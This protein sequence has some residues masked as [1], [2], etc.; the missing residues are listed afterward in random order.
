[1]KSLLDSFFEG[2]AAVLLTTIL[3]PGLITHS[4]F[5]PPLLL[6]FALALLNSPN[7]L[8]QITSPKALE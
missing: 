2:I 1:L 8:D 6:A 4:Y 3:S 5:S 7:I